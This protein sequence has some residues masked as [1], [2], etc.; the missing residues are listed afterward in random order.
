MQLK[1]QLHLE[2]DVVNH[3]SDYKKNTIETQVSGLSIYTEK[4]V[5]LNQ[6]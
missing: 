1:L 2:K 6:L 4:N 3:M 5:S